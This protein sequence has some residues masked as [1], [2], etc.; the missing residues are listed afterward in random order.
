MSPC[1]RCTR[2]SPCRSCRPFG[3]AAS[4]RAT[5]RAAPR[6]FRLVRMFVLVGLMP[7]KLLEGD[8][9]RVDVARNVVSRLFMCGCGGRGAP[10]A[11]SGPCTAT[12]RA[13]RLE[14]LDVVRDD[15]RNAPL[16][17]V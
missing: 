8:V 11:H 12:A 2:P 9:V 15:L 5:S 1:S 3:A 17:A 13:S 4:E 10:S 7:W 6:I 14:K 16:L